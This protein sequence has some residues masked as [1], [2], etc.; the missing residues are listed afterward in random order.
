LG[1]KA[2]AILDG[3]SHAS[4]DDVRAVAHPV[5]RHRV[6][7]NFNAESSGTTS[8][9]VID[10]LLQDLPPRHSGDE[11]APALARAFA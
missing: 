3:R 2:R 6:I 10:R 4:S 8:D 9:H 11:I 1:A 5:L 7:T